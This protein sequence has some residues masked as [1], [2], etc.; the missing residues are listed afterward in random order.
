MPKL[1]VR[2]AQRLP[3][4]SDV[5]GDRSRGRGA[6]Q[7]R[8]EEA[9]EP[10]GADVLAGVPPRP[11]R[12][13][14]R[15]G[16]RAPRRPG[17][18]ARGLRRARP[19]GGGAGAPAADD[20]AGRRRAAL[21][22]RR[23]PPRR[24]AGTGGAGVA[25]PG[26]RATGAA[27]RRRS[28]RRA[29]RGCGRR[30]ARTSRGWPGTSPTASTPRTSPRWSGSPVGWSTDGLPIGEPVEQLLQLAA[31]VVAR[32][33]LADGEPQRRQL[34]RQVLGVGLG[35]LGPRPVLLEGDAVAVVLPVL[36]QQD[37]RR[38]VR[39]LGRERQVEQD[40]RV[41]V[42]PPGAR[43]RGSSAIQM[44]TTIG[45]EGQER[46]GAQE[47]REPLGEPAERRPGR[48]L[49]NRRRRSARL[50]QPSPRRASRQALRASPVRLGRSGG[51]ASRRAAGGPARRR[52]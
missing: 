8:D 31:Q 52:R 7:H 41:R 24:P 45:L 42:P 18:F 36:R 6:E 34:A 29:S 48:C 12:D 35:A 1:Y 14:P 39:G 50:V 15:A 9:P 32:H 2:A 38:G 27:W 19:A 3:A 33:D 11:R 16:G 21:A 5:P 40:E 4:P 37:Q 20:R 49:E 22:F 25:L 30:R 13:H 51:P 26:R 43:R 47:P 23:H 28:P 46:A 10:R 44:I 17:A